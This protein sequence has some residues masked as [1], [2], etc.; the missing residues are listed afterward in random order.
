MRK[1]LFIVKVFITMQLH[2]IQHIRPTLGTQL[3]KYENG[4]SAAFEAGN[5]KNRRQSEM[6][7]K[8]KHKNASCL[9]CTQL[10]WKRNWKIF[11]TEILLLFLRF[12]FVDKNRTSISSSEFLVI[13][14]FFS[15]FQIFSRIF[16]FFEI[17]KNLVQRNSLQTF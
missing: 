13:R 12:F 8:L 4:I 6:N 3:C 10:N 7:R 16:L 9:V 5:K 17:A 11:I 1:L 14:F 2:R 15:F